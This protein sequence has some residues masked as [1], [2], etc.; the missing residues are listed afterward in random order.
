[1][2]TQMSLIGRYQK[3]GRYQELIVIP[4]PN[5][6]LL[7]LIPIDVHSQLFWKIQEFL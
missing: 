6:R 4:G 7:Q 5:K 3:R 1:M 2:L